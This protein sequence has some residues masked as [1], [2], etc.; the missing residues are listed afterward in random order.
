MKLH[1]EQNNVTK[2]GVTEDSN[3]SIEASAKAFFILSDG[4]Y[5]NKVKAVIRELSTNAYDS[6]IDEGVADKPFDVHLPT[7]LEPTFYVRD[8]GTSMTHDECMSLYTTYFRST[9]ND[10]NDAVGC[11]GLGSKAPFAYCDQFTGEAYLDGNV[12]TYTAYKDESGSPVFSLL[13]ER[14]TDKPNGIKVSIA[15]REDD[16]WE[17]ESEAKMLFRF[18]NVKPNMVGKSVDIDG[19]EVVLSGSNWEFV[20]DDYK[21]YVIMGQ[22]A[23]PVDEDDVFSYPVASEDKDAFDFLYRSRGLRIYANI[24]DVDITPS[25][26]SLS[27]NAATKRAIKNIIEEMSL[28]IAI[29]MERQV[30]NQPTLYKA[31]RQYLDLCNQC[32]SLSSVMESLDNA[33]TYNNNPLWDSE[34]GEQIEVGELMS[35]KHYYKGEW[36]KKIDVEDATKINLRH[37]T[38]IVIDDLQRGGL[39]RIRNYIKEKCSEGFSGYMYKAEDLNEN[40]NAASEFLELL[41]DAEIEDCILTSSLPKPYREYSYGGGGGASVQ[42][43]V[44][45]HETNEF[46]ECKI[47]VKEEDAYYIEESRGTVYLQ[48]EDYSTSLAKETLAMR[49]KIIADHADSIIEH[50]IFLVKPSVARNKR[51]SERDGWHNGSKLIVRYMNELIEE[52]YEMLNKHRNKPEISTERSGRRIAKAV[53]LTTTDNDLKKIHA[54]WKEYCADIVKNE[55]VCDQ[56]FRFEHWATTEVPKHEEDNS[57]SDRYDKALESYPMISHCDTGWYALEDGQAQDFANYIDLIENSVDK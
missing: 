40:P 51:L 27:Y 38:K 4:L 13:D 55:H 30:S 35:V 50:K 22:I 36:R 20:K 52:N 18:F 31:R 39:S 23:Y 56:L 16:V 37:N 19:S 44:Y 9:R 8:Y 15:V 24:G 2:S 3:F 12:R 29:D 47:S 25:R 45:N 46:T 34:I 43:Q 33:I 17:F 10:S 54:E 49:L 1:A 7:R 14:E 5:S 28:E 57:F 41:G 53:E 6:H 32:K 21:N 42:G 48:F 11:L 26:E